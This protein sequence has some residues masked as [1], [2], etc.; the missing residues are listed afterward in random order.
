MA[1]MGKGLRSY[2]VAAVL[3]RMADEGARLA[4]LLLALQRTG[5]AALGGALV[6]ALLVPHVVAAPAVGLLTDRVRRPRWVLAAA[7]A[8]FAAALAVA[9][10]G[11]GRLPTAL[12][13]AILLVGGGCGPA[14]TG[15]LTSQL[16]A[17]VPEHSLPRAFG[18]DSASYNLAGIAGPTLAAVLA[19][20]L[21]AT[22][23][24]LTLAGCAALG[25]LLLTLLPLPRR[26]S[27]EAADGSRLGDGV[28]AVVRDPVLGTV[29]AASSLAQL[30]AGALPVV[31]AVLSAR[32]QRP[33]ATG[34]LM[35]AVAVGGLVGSLLWTWRPARPDRAARTV[36]LSLLG[37]G[38]ALAPAAAA[39]SV[40]VT[41][42]LFAL[43]GVF[44]GPLTGALFT[45]RQQRAAPTLQAQVFTIGAG[46]KTSCAAGGAA[47]GGLIVGLSGP[48]QLA[49]VAG[50]PVVAG[51]V[52]LGAL[53]ALRAPATGGAAPW[54]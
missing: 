2:L 7:A 14:L 38:L 13:V 25:A 9:A 35:T 32:A 39:E 5:S 31:A 50:C 37:V 36:M 52:G 20:L 40:L 30:G 16:R 51:A 47:L 45:V 28:T 48:T 41:G 49:L 11:L 34:L 27:R 42:A 54:A 29:T 22:G 23:G 18:A 17:L 12:V 44:L 46:V 3:V 8:G 43:S 53:R 4:L 33:E 21:G 24:T 1:T 15:G 26:R 19:G 10:G 6:A